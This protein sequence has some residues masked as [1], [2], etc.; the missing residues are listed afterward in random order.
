M[1]ILNLHIMQGTDSADDVIV[2]GDDAGFQAAAELH[3][4]L[5]AAQE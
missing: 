4:R 3:V 2:H 5:A 1:F